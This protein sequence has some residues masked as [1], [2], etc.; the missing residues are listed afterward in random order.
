MRR[1]D[2][3]VVDQQDEIGVRIRVDIAKE[4]RALHAT[5]APTDRERPGEELGRRSLANAT[6]VDGDVTASKQ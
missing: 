5:T 4:S 3:S 1:P 2:G 6:S